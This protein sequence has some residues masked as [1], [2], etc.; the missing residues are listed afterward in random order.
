MISMRVRSLAPNQ[1]DQEDH[2]TNQSNPA[3]QWVDVVREAE[4]R[5]SEEENSASSSTTDLTSGTSNTHAKQ[6]RVVSTDGILSLSLEQNVIQD[7][8]RLPED[9]Q[10][11][12]VVSA[13][14]LRYDP[15]GWQEH[16]MTLIETDTDD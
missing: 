15:L 3:D 16:G 13:N 12:A 4:C 5:L 10:F 8:L 6:T 14:I 9:F 1:T 2:T 11:P 7:L